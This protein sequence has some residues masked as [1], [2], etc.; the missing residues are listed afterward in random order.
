[1]FKSELN[2]QIDTKL[3]EKERFT[4]YMDE[5]LRNFIGSI[6]IG[7][8]IYYFVFQTPPNVAFIWFSVD[9]L[10][11]V[12]VFF[13]YYGFYKHNNLF[14]F[15]TWKAL[16]Y[17]P[18]LIFSFSLAIAPWLF[19]QSQTGIYLY[20]MMIMIVSLSGTIS[21]ASSYYV[22][23][24]TIFLTLPL[25]SL[26]VKFSTMESTHELIIYGLIA[27]LWISIITFAQRISRSLLNSIKLKLEN[28]Q[29]RA[30]SERLNIEKSK[31][32]AAASHD[33]RQPLQ[34]VNLLV[35][36]L[37]SKNMNNE[38]KILFE[39]LES[40][41]NSMSELL[42]SLLDVS[43]L[44]AHVIVP[45]PQHICLNTL[46]LK[47]KS[48]FK[49]FTTAKGINL[50]MPSN[51]YVVFADAILL[52]QIL[53]N[54]LSNAIR[55]THLGSI[56]IEVKSKL[57]QIQIS[58]KDTGIGIA[59]VDQKAIFLEFHQLHN[60][61]RDQQNGLG[62]GLSIVKRLCE[63]QDWP[64]SVN[65]DIG[66]G[67]CF[68]FSAPQGK[69]DLVLVTEKFN[70]NKNLAALNVIIVDDHKG[71]RFSLSQM[72]SDWGCTV[73]S[74][75]SADMACDALNK[76]P[77]WKPN[78]II[79]DYRL[80]NHLTGIDAI[81]QIKTVLNYAIE[82]ILMSGDTSPEIIKKIEAADLFL[83]HKPIKPAKLRVILTRRM[84]HLIELNKEKL[85]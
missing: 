40:S 70:V 28:I 66:V 14:C 31:F 34:A 63:L 38:D 71:I 30:D 50:V 59:E 6:F 29:A 1:L 54:L 5:M 23:R 76:S 67:S 12:T 75:E 43:K 79:S 15:T 36:T 45:I 49:P 78:L 24:H 62:L 11:A 20:C 48:Q 25:L 47:L 32:I 4:L 52:E 22:E 19:L 68:S 56:T 83:L 55:Y 37:K 2:E 57:G 61:E 84:N 39:H 16:S 35:S 64:L 18:L 60:P 46:L 17:I 13:T 80:R 81:A 65:S 3:F 85:I 8:P 58:V 9:A 27:L 41:V 44:D 10:L 7:L 51:D 26:A 74:Y 73:H 72:L 42:N 82:S 53:N 21:H 77:T 69:K 33:I